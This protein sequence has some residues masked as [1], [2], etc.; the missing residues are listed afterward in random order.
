MSCAGAMPSVVE[1]A[2]LLLKD[3]HISPS[4]FESIVTM[5]EAVRTKQ[6]TPGSFVGT[7]LHLPILA[8]DSLLAAP[9]TEGL[10]GEPAGQNIMVR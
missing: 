6:H 8:S 4:Q 3:G 7:N 1:Q 9:D 5:E 2:R 10:A